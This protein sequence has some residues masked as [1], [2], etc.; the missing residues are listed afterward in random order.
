MTRRWYCAIG[1][2]IFFAVLSANIPATFVDSALS[3]PS[4]GKLR[5]VEARGTLWSGEG[6]LEIRDTNGLVGVAKPVSWQALPWSLIRGH[7]VFN[8]V[9]DQSPKSFP[10][11]ISFSR[12]EIT[13][14]N[15]SLPAVALGLA[16]P[17]LAP[18]GLGGQ[19]SLHISQAFVQQ[20]SVRGNA[21][22]Q[23]RAARSTLTP[24]A[25]FG[26]YELTIESDGEMPHTTL[27]TL[28]GPLQIDG[29]DSPASD[30]Q[31]MFLVTLSVPA[32]LQQQMVPL[33]RLI[34]VERSP[35]LFEL[36]VK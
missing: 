34:A 36:K 2:G 35:G 32:D 27:R 28:Q 16:V 5:L 10:V 29:K 25:P 23:W 21:T 4:A 15:I 22:V 9:L 8:I 19:V 30:G 13:E 26:D 11:A 18:L 3:R 1:I 33:L 17:T 7:L 6:Q 31:R 20:N 14:A 12:I 24:V